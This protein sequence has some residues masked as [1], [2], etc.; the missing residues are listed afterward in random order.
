MNLSNKT[1]NCTL[2]PLWVN[3]RALERT[4]NQ[5]L[6]IIENSL[7]KLKYDALEIISERANELL[8]CLSRNF[9]L[10]ISEPEDDNPQTIDF[11]LFP[12]LINSLIDITLVSKFKVVPNEVGMLNECSGYLKIIEKEIRNVL[13]H[14]SK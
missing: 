2:I 6:S 9:P 13:G 5:L 7:E 10:S 12:K 3:V 8:G 11:V 14:D 1:L 4:I